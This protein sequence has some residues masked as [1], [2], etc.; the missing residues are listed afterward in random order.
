MFQASHLNSPLP[1]PREDHSLEKETPG[2]QL[3]DLGRRL[4]LKMVQKDAAEPDNWLCL[5]SN[6]LAHSYF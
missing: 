6:E 5:Q 4:V 1:T 3:C 2:R